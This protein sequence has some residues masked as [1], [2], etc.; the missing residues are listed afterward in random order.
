M[1]MARSPAGKMYLEKLQKDYDDTL[2][3]LLYAP[4]HDLQTLQGQLRAL[5]EQLELFRRA[6]KVTNG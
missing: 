4:V 2:K 3:K 1:A 6:D 5:H